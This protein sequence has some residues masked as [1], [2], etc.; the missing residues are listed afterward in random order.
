MASDQ[1]SSPESAAGKSDIGKLP[2]SVQ[3]AP[4]V[5]AGN[6]AAAEQKVKKEFKSKLEKSTDYFERLRAIAKTDYNAI[7]NLA[8]N[9]GILGKKD[10]QIALLGELEALKTSDAAKDPGYWDQL[11]KL[12]AIANKTAESSAAYQKAD[13]LRHA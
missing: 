3:G 6:W 11:A 5:P 10:K 13:Q 4:P 9:Y 1:K 7:A 12:Y 2:D 8:E